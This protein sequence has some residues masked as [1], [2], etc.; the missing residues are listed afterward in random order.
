L[1][2]KD[3]LP[4][5]EL[6]ARLRHAVIGELLHVPPKS[7]QLRVLLQ[8]KARKIYSHPVTGEPIQ[9]GYST[10]E[11]WYY[12]ARKSQDPVISLRERPRS[13]AGKLRAWTPTAIKILTALYREHPG[14]S[15]QLTADNLR[16]AL[17]EEEPAQPAPSY[18]SVRR[19]MKS[20]GFFRR[21]RPKRDTA[22]ARAAVERLEQWEVRSYETEYVNALWHADFHD[23]SRKVL[24][25]GGEWI[26]PQLLCVIDDHSRLVCHA[27]WYTH[28]ETEH[29]VHGLSQALQRRGRPQKLMTDNGAAMKGG[30]F[31][32]GLARLSISF[33]PTLEYSPYQNGKQE[34]YF[35]QV[36][37]RLM[38]MLE[39]VKDEEMTLDYLNLATHA[40]I[41]MEY[42]QKRHDEIG[43]API[44]RYL[45]GRNVGRECPSSDRLRNDFRIQVKRT[46]RRSDGTIS[47][48]A[49][50]FEIPNRYRHLETVYLRYARWDLSRVDL[51][52]PQTDTILCPL[53]PLDKAAN[54]DG[55]RRR[56][57]PL[58]TDPLP[59]PSSTGVAPA[60]RKMLADYAATG[61]PPP[62]IPL[63]DDNPEDPT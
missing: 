2:S 40:W 47:L 62:Y 30:E 21:P 19:Y 51:V 55:M 57:V 23:G 42:N 18:A 26:I 39:T 12:R 37:G 27:Q 31:L 25:R 11:R 9:F 56:L 58:Q 24:T 13:H 45:E 63:D 35:G 29:L 15:T 60:L 36:E 52:E 41:E 17:S 3:A 33:D 7:G 38:A 20:Q 10:L 44:R 6:W 46:Q 43:V 28:E 14:W 1:S 4:P 59:E 54:A 5:R 16:V 49:R 22:G 61:L 48:E 53:Y 8:E 32:E 34:S 50:R